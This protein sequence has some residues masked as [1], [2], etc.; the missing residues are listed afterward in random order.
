[1]TAIDRLT[2][3]GP[4]ARDAAIRSTLNQIFDLREAGSTD[5]TDYGA[6]MREVSRPRAG[7][8]A[9]TTARRVSCAAIATAMDPDQVGRPIGGAPVMVAVCLAYGD[10]LNPDGRQRSMATTARRELRELMETLG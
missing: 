5:P 1:M 7:D 3:G 2:F 4:E 9:P 8:D 6:A 10:P